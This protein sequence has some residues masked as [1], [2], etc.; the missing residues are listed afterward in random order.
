MQILAVDLAN[1][2]Q[3]V[4]MFQAAAEDLITLANQLQHQGWER[5][6]LPPDENGSY[7]LSIPGEDADLLEAILTAIDNLR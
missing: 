6:P 2:T 7:R 1:L 4:A 5:Q 3:R